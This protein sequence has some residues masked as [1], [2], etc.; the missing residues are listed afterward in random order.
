MRQAV[1]LI[2]GGL[3]L[4]LLGYLTSALEIGGSA[5]AFTGAAGKIETRLQT[6]VDAVV[7]ELGYE[8]ITAAVDGQVVIFEG[9]SPRE[10]ETAAAR[11][12]L[13]AADGRGG[14]WS[15]GVLFVRDRSTLAPPISPYELRATASEER[16]TLTGAMPTREARTALVEY[17]DRLFQGGVDNQLIIARGAPDEAGW[18]ATSRTA[19]SQMAILDTSRAIIK[20]KRLSLEGR[21]AD[22]GVRSRVTAAIAKVPSPFIATTRIEAPEGADVGVIDGASDGSTDRI[23]DPD[24]C[25]SM[26]DSFTANAGVAFA[27]GRAEIERDSY[28]LLDRLALTA[29]RCDTLRVLIGGHTDSSGDPGANLRLSQKRAQAVADYFVLLGVDQARLVA[30]GFGAERPIAENE[31]P[32]GRALNRRIEFEVRP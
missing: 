21:A 2:I 19:V 11:A 5:A 18:A 14:F 27:S 4:A 8:W 15:G 30:R 16:I 17:A 3:A 23:E 29:K 7:E 20:D 32:E 6:A 10:E 12:A 22:A 1:V 13:L 31:T 28:G 24:V 9:V 25:Q 26:F